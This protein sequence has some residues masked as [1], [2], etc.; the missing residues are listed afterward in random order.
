MPQHFLLLSATLFAI[1]IAVVLTRRC[2]TTVLLGV[3]LLFQAVNLALAALTSKF[4]DWEGRIAML[5]LMSIAMVELVAGLA[6][7]VAQHREH[8]T[9]EP[10]T[11]RG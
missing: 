4:Q 10:P 8:P 7:I 6:A 2:R 9:G 3:Q 1:G 5:A 11:G